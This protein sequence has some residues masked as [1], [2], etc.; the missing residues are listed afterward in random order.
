MQKLNLMLSSLAITLLVSQAVQ[1]ASTPLSPETVSVPSRIMPLP[2][3]LD[4][5]PMLNSNSPEVVQSE[6]VL[7]SH[8]FDFNGRFDIFAHH[9]AKADPPGDL[10]TL[11]L[12]VLLHNPGKL[13]AT[14]DVISGASY[15]SQPDAPFVP[16][17]AVVDNTDGSVFAGPGDR[18]AGEVLRG[19]LQKDLFP[20]TVR[21]EP[22]ATRVLA[23]LP[24]PVRGL[25][26]PLNG[27]SLLARLKT[28]QRVQASTVA[29]FAKRDATGGERPP[30]ESD[31]AA[32]LKSGKL[33]GP[34]DKTPSLPNAEGAVVYGR[35][36]GVQEGTTWSGRIADES[37]G[38]KLTV[39]ALGKSISFPLSTVP[40]GTFGTGQVQSAP[41]LMRTAD[42]A[43]A[44]HGNYGVKYDLTIPL[45][46]SSKRDLLVLVKLQ[47][48]IKSDE[49]ADCLTFYKEPS[50][51]V[52]FRGTVKSSYVDSQNISH[53]KY[54]HLVQHQGEP[55]VPLVAQYLKPKES[56]IVK[57]ELIYPPDA[58]PPHVV[59]I[60]SSDPEAMQD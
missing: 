45:V 20:A 6:G 43:Y 24:I 47:S 13:P 28:D 1:S 15:L 21:L 12:G 26:P 58:T 46:N 36:S 56:R 23:A 34:R 49:K 55:G 44:A 48:P 3:G 31:W 57:I 7:T 14:V 41:L 33:A 50:A 5:V 54:T 40:R 22:G 18:V 32:A 59:T 9:I 52:F 2:G 60:E 10:S 11:Y 4:K 16:V 38:A 39:P 35:V 27:R 19:R 37:D 30:E 25:T 53:E 42:T 51:R 29:L 8:P 17:P